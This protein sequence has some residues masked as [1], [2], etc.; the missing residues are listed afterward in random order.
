MLAAMDLP[1]ISYLK[2]HFNNFFALLTSTSF[3]NHSSFILS[4]ASTT[5]HEYPTSF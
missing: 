4:K 3:K 5:N 1:Q 2:Y